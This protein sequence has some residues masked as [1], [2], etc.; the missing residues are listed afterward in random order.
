MAFGEKL[1]RSLQCT[2]TYIIPII[3]LHDHA[4]GI[5][6]TAVLSFSF[7]ARLST[8]AVVIVVISQLHPLP[9]YPPPRA[10]SGSLPESRPPRHLPSYKDVVTSQLCPFP[11]VLPRL[12]ARVEIV[13][14]IA[15]Q[16]PAYI[17]LSRPLACLPR[18][19]R[20]LSLRDG[21]HSVCTNTE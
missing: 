10:S 17:W 3:R 13:E 18:P 7:L 19:G 6:C 21:I 12:E 5:P 11:L 20:T 1:A 8:H 2:W 4:D 15:A 16:I 9:L 14:A